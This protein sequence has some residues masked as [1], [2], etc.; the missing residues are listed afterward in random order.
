MQLQSQS[1]PRLASWCWRRD[2]PSSCSSKCSA[3][4]IPFRNRFVDAHAWWH[5]CLI[6]LQVFFHS[7]HYFFYTLLPQLQS[8]CVIDRLIH[9]PIQP[10]PPQ[11]PNT[12]RPSPVERPERELDRARLA[13]SRRARRAER[14]ARRVGA[15]NARRRSRALAGRRGRAGHRG[16]AV[17]ARRGGGR[18]RRL[19]RRLEVIGLS[20]VIFSEYIASVEI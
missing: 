16:A 11:P 17:R 20:L 9:P 4:P 3:L 18:R 2:A 12:L 7:H 14:A 5:S 8:L 15:S 19:W 13:D 6:R 1:T 10:I